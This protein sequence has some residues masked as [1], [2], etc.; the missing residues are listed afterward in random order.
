[1]HNPLRCKKAPGK[2]NSGREGLK[3]KKGSLSFKTYRRHNFRLTTFC[4][5]NHRSVCNVATWVAK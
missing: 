5:Q 4:Y 1:M 2:W 3:S